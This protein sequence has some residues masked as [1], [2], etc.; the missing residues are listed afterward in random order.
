MSKWNTKT[1]KNKYNN[2]LLIDA[3]A[4]AAALVPV[5]PHDDAVAREDDGHVLGR[6]PHQ[7][8]AGVQAE[9]GARGLHGVGGAGER[10]NL[11]TNTERTTVKDNSTVPKYK[12]WSK[13]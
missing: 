13:D 11:K 4:A 3:G 9:E 1:A 8:L 12:R 10:R 6:A 2:H 7:G 5:W